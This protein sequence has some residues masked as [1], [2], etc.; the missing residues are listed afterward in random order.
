M[1]DIINQAITTVRYPF[2]KLSHHWNVSMASEKLM[3]IGLNSPRHRHSVLT[4]DSVI[5]FKSAQTIFS[6]SLSCVDEK[7]I[8]RTIL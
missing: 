7:H 5:P 4:F 1:C 6:T 3:T 2:L 8:M